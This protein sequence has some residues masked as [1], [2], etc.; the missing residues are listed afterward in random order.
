MLDHAARTRV[1]VLR[2]HN[3][4]DETDGLS[5]QL[6]LTG[7]PKLYDGDGHVWFWYRSTGVGP[8][9]CMSALQ[10]LEVVVDDS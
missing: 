1:K 6:N 7:S 9:P 8:Y 5:F 10:A 4:T 2:R 3:P